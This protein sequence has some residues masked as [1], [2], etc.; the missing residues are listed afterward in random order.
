MGFALLQE[1]CVVG[2]HCS[3]MG[4]PLAV[5]ALDISGRPGQQQS[6]AIW[7]LGCCD[8]GSPRATLHPGKPVSHP[9]IPQTPAWSH[10]LGQGTALPSFSQR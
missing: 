4:I 8:L 7:S 6:L 5:L 2:G 3:E 1:D 10:P 9:Q